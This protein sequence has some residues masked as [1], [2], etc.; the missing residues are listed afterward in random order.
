MYRECKA[1]VKLW[2]GCVGEERG[3]RIAVAV[4]FGLG[5]GVTAERAMKGW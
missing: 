3:V 5:V 2:L 1:A 4:G